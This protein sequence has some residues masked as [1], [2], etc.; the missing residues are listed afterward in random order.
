MARRLPLRLR[1]QLITTH[2]PDAPLSVVEQNVPEIDS[3]LFIDM[4]VLPNARQVENERNPVRC[5]GG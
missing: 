2:R 1:E 5:K 3:R 4:W